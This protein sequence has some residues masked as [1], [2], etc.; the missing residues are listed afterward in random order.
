[1]LDIL[2]LSFKV[3]ENNKINIFPR[4]VLILRPDEETTQL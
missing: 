3:N 1:M 4:V 2:K